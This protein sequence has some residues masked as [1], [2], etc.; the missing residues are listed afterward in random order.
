MKF[1]SKRDGVELHLHL[2]GAFR[3]ETVFKY[4]QKKSI[5]VP[6]SNA[7]AFGDG[8]I[9]KTPNSLASFLKTFDYL[10]PPVQGD[11]VSEVHL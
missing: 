8:L 9:V 6:W 7:S 2:D 10:L 3:P 11:E 1:N 5:Q 4:T